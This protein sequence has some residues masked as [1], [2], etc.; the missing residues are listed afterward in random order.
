MRAGLWE[1]S[2]TS[3]GRTVTH[4]ACITPAQEEGSKGSIASMRE[5]IEKALA[6]SG[7]CKLQEFTVVENTRTELM[8]C[9]AVVP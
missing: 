1:N 7:A 3:S 5:A 8:V 9:G 2:V 4:N 6:K